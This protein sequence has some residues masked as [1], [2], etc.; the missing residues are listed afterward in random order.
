MMLLQ[1]T[2]CRSCEKFTYRDLSVWKVAVFVLLLLGALLAGDV[3]EVVRGGLA[4][5]YIAV[6]SFVALTLIIF[7][8]LEKVF[9]IDWEVILKRHERYQP[10]IASLLGALPGCGGAIIA[11][12]QYVM[13]RLSFGGMVAVLTSTMGDAA[14]LLIARE[15]QTALCVLLGSIVIGAVSGY[16]VDG[17][18]G[19]DFLRHKHKDDAAVIASKCEELMDYTKFVSIP[20]FLMLIPGVALGFGNAFLVDTN[21]WFV[22]F[23][24]LDPTL[25]IGAIG[26]VM[27]VGF[28]ALLP[29]R[30]FSMVNLAAHPACAKRVHLPT[31]IMFDTNF[32][33][34]W[35][36][37][38]FLSFELLIYYTEFDLKSVFNTARIYMP[39][40]GVLIG[41]IP[42]CGP[43]IITT[44]LYLNGL[45]PLSAQIGNA[46][47]NDGDALFPALALAP[48]AAILATAYT[49]VPAVIAAYG[50][51]FLFE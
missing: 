37:F 29:E 7:H 22:G 45:I 40:M 18:H 30:D 41:F 36:V 1:S 4:D 47:S 38:A 15:P 44:T 39:I 23:E 12:T 16:I 6:T 31:K 49:A 11:M 19:R 17:I 35:V 13:G 5:A 43:Q 24:H 2:S 33:T 8:G 34:A 25:W 27:C 9:K 3:S 20:W 10:I 14:F 46:L 51:Y 42:G 32:V 28:W 21:T 26:A 48:R 50:Y